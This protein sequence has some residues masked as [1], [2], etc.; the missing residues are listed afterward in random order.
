MTI[1]SSRYVEV[2]STVVANVVDAAVSAWILATGRWRDG[3]SWLDNARWK[4]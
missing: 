4:D 2:V 3:G 1:P